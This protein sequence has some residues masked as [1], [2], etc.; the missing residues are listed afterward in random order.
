MHIP[1]P[2][3]DTGVI[4]ARF[5]YC[6]LHE[7]HRALLDL[8][9]SHHDRVIVFLGVAPVAAK[10]RNPIDYVSRQRMV[11]EYNPRIEC[12]PLHDCRDDQ[13][14][15]HALD[16]TLTLL[17]KP[18]QTVALYGG[19]DSFVSHYCGKFKA[20][21]LESPFRIS[22]TEL[23]NRI[24]NQVVNSAD[25]R[26]GQIYNAYAAYPTSYTCVDIAVLDLPNNRIA[27]GR[28]VGQ[29]E[30]RFPGGFVEP[31]HTCLA[32]AAQQ[33]TT[34]ELGL[35]YDID[36]FQYLTDRRIDDWRYRYEVDKILSVLF[37]VHHTFGALTAGDDLQEAEWFA[38]DQLPPLV[39]EHRPFMTA[40]THYL[41][42]RN[43]PVH[44]SAQ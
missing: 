39:K 11:Q 42:K 10:P 1:L 21:E 41:Q 40:L 13:E 37:V 2:Q 27:L 19:R 8:V 15:S 14:W 22:S 9:L 25:F 12:Y 4:V 20:V 35:T 16:K 6:E 36:T 31:H 29:K 38:L 34:E 28:K 32:H 3:A 43:A 30:W 33:E 7:G 44:T 24:A 26:K 5:Q 23:R 18:G 17:L